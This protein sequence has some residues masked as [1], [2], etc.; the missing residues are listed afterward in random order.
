MCWGAGDAIAAEL[1][2]VLDDLRGENSVPSAM[3]SPPPA[4]MFGFFGQARSSGL[5]P[6]SFRKKDREIA[7]HF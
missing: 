6:V 5:C 1:A 2:L 3:G 4:M 7:V